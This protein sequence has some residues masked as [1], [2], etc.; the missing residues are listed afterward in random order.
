[1]KNIKKLDRNEMKAVLGGLA[2]R[3][4]D[5]Y[6]PGASICCGTLCRLPRQCNM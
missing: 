4:D 2:C 6:C 3:T 1:M 5:G